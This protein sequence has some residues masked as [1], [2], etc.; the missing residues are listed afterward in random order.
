MTPE[1]IKTVDSRGYIMANELFEY[2][3][4]VIIMISVNDKQGNDARTHLLKWC[5]G[6]VHAQMGMCQTV[7][8]E[9]SLEANSQLVTNIARAATQP[10]PDPPAIPEPAPEPP[11]G[12][13]PT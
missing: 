10:P 8:F 12:D 11:L 1:M 4:A 3:D 7:L 5:R 13:M 9:R 2:A 6:D